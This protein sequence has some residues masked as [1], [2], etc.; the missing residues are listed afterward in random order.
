M[1]LKTNPEDFRVYE[2][3]TLDVSP[4][5]AGKNFCVYLLKKRN[6]NTIDALREACGAKRVPI[7]KV[8][9]GGRKDK[10]AVSEQFITCPIGYD[11]NFKRHNVEVLRVGFSSEP[12]SPTKIAG[13]EF[14]IVA[15]D[16]D[17]NEAEKALEM[18]SNKNLS[19]F[20]NFFDE[21]RFGG[22]E[23]FLAE[24]LV[25]RQFERALE[26]WRA[27]PDSKKNVSRADTIRELRLIPRQEFGMFISAYQSHIWNEVCNRMLGENFEV[28]EIPTVAPEILPADARISRIIETVLRERGVRLSKLKL[29]EFKSC[30]YF[31]SFMRRVRVFPQGFEAFVED[32]EI[33]EGRK[34]IS[35]KFSLPA[36]AYA[37]MFLRS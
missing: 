19:G 9:Y 28:G 25:K 7:E 3:I 20:I 31:S 32:D 30:G 16:M 17:E 23:K 37:T 11:L 21:Q 26:M 10:R 4:L 35:I 1:R 22:S 34:K 14:F 29:D 33:F 13:N 8:R 6:W 24:L 5:S 2:R 36:G 27:K 15:R 12:M 18:F